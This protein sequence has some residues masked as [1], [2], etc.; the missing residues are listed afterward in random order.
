[1]DFTTRVSESVLA[2]LH[3]VV[4]VPAGESI[5]SIDEAVLERQLVDATR[6]WDEDLGEAARAEHGEEAA[7]RLS[8]LYGRAFPEAY[9]ED[10]TS[11]VGVAD[12]RHMDALESDDVDRAQPVPGARRARPTSAA[13]SSTAAARSR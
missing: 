10:F 5:P 4:R 12:I 2:R 3:F 6:T 9:K 13:S 7:A 11:R 1:M 8:G